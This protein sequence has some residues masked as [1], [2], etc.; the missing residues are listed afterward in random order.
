MRILP[1]LV[2][3]TLFPLGVCFAQTKAPKTKTQTTTKNKLTETKAK[4]P[5]KA[6]EP[7]HTGTKLHPERERAY[8]QAYKTGAVSKP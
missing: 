7:V 3:T 6:R 1:L 5:K 4:K 2:F 8:A